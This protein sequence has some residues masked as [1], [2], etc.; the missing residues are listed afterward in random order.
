MKNKASE[1]TDAAMPAFFSA[2]HGVRAKISRENALCDERDAAVALTAKIRKELRDERDAAVVLAA[3]LH[4]ELRDERDA[5]VALAVNLHKELRDER[6]AAVAL[7]ARPREGAAANRARGWGM[8]TTQGGNN[9]AATA[10]G[11]HCPASFQNSVHESMFPRI[12][13][14]IQ[15]KNFT[16]QL[17]ADMRRHVNDK[18]ASQKSK[19]VLVPQCP[20][21]GPEDLA[22]RQMTWIEL[23]EYTWKVMADVRRKLKEEAAFKKGYDE[24]K[25]ANRLVAEAYKVEETAKVAAMADTRAKKA[26]AME[27][28]CA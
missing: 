15:I 4:K 11:I 3:S 9:M 12:V 21:S 19:K 1:Q 22:R 6:D 18:T 10:M 20:A 23:R 25:E 16:R 7:A 26:A 5:A 24:V 2:T 14:R 8:I 28:M 17:I 27:P 13:T